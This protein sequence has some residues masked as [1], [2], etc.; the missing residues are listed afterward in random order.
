[1]NSVLMIGTMLSTV[2]GLRGVCEA[3]VDRLALKGWRVIAASRNR[4]KIFRLGDMLVTAVKHRHEYAV[5][6]V[7]VFSGAAFFYAEAVAW[8]LRRLGKPYVLTL[9]GGNL[10]EFAKSWPRRVSRLLTSAKVVI[11]PS[12]F[13]KEKMECYCPEIRIIPNP[14]DLS[15]YPYRRRGPVHLKLLWL[16]AFHEIYNPTMAV[17]VVAALAAKNSGIQLTMVGP[18]KGDGSLQRAQAEVAA[19]MLGEQ[20]HFPG[21]VPK[22]EVPRMLAGA[23]V[24]LNTANVDNSPVSVIEAMACGLCVVSTRAGGMPFLLANEQNGLLVPCGDIDAMAAGITRFLSDSELAGRVSG[25]ARRLAEKF[26]WSVVLP[27]WESLFSV[28]LHSRR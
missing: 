2:G 8:T 24:F 15:L 26:D 3:L 13:L 28:I 5:A 23:D 22:P 16:R 17:K 1:M 21:Q 6:Q 14:I 19:S 4:S 7:D 20:V 10:P 27:A 9:R 11:A 12:G 18:D 25:N